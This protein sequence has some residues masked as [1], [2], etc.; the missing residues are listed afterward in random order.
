MTWKWRNVSAPVSHSLVP[1]LATGTSIGILSP[2]SPSQMRKARPHCFRL[3]TQLICVALVLAL[4]SA[5]KSI[6][7][8]MAITATTT[9]SMTR[10]NPQVLE[11]MRA[12][13]RRWFLISSSYPRLAAAN[14]CPANDRLSSPAPRVLPLPF[15]ESWL[16]LTVCQ[17]QWKKHP[18]KNNLLLTCALALA[19]IVAPL[20][21]VLAQPAPALTSASKTSFTE[22]TAQLDPGGNF[23]LYL[24]TAQWLEHLSSK[25]EGWRH[26][27]AA[28]PDLTPDKTA[29]LN[30]TFDIVT[31]VIKDSGVEDITGM[32]LSSVE[33]E[34][35]MF[36]NKM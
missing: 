22:V 31:R 19:G 1:P 18:M 28:M 23:F 30:K 6:A 12:S 17:P 27:F 3:L 33:I 20:E 26:T 11:F 24:G 32:G 7:A 25:V 4:A 35:G 21:S 29:Y 2:L 10:V 14:F 13:S 34:K 16:P 36:R 9:S 8:R 15:R 5:G